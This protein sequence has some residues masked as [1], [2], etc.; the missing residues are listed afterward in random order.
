MIYIEQDILER[1][2]PFS[3]DRSVS[4]AQDLCSEFADAIPVEYQED[5]LARVEQAHIA[6]KSG[7]PAV[8]QRNSAFLVHPRDSEAS[9]EQGIYYADADGVFPA[10]TYI[11][12]PD[13]EYN[14]ELQK[15]KLALLNSLPPSEVA[16]TVSQAFDGSLL[17][18]SIVCIPL[19]IDKMLQLPSASAKINGYARP[20]IRDAVDFVYNK[21][22]TQN[23]GLG[24]QLAAMTQFGQWLEDNFKEKIY[25]TTGHAGTIFAMAESLRHGAEKLGIDLTNETI[26]V[27][28]CGR[29]GSVFAEYAEAQNLVGNL[30]LYDKANHV[31][32][33]LA[34]N[35][36][37]N[38]ATKNGH[39]IEV[40]KNYEDV[41]ERTRFIVSAV[42]DPLLGELQLDNHFVVDDSQP[43]WVPPQD[44]SGIIVWP[45]YTMPQDIHRNGI[46]MINAARKEE[47]DKY[48]YGP[49][50]LVP[51]TDWGCNVELTT[52][53]MHGRMETNHISRAVSKD[54]VEE[55]GRLIT[56]AGFSVQTLQSWGN[57]IPEES[58]TQ[59]KAHI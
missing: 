54:D 24:E 34:A 1:E 20:L 10:L 12:S 8:E 42:S 6:Y 9:I 36:I 5:L 11:S 33:K 13:G 55:M 2:E 19:D 38:R 57:I 50:G 37:K 32:E 41:L 26:G 35:L 17:H 53:L 27:I 43:P 23:I 29:I 52:L 30:I 56:E 28:G 31:S 22:G 4:I 16:T 59:L 3:L 47:E 14:K 46:R 21:I 58:F 51:R 7:L 25:T 40:A 49:V 39:Q 48:N 45:S 15:R 44:S 18:G